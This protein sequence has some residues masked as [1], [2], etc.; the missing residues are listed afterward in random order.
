ML[1]GRVPDSG[2]CLLAG[3]LSGVLVASVVSG[4]TG[5]LLMSLPTCSFGWYGLPL[6]MGCQLQLG[7]HS[8][9]GRWWGGKGVAGD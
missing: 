5:S 7:E 4:S 6:S 1:E 9:R 2:G 3:S 8:S